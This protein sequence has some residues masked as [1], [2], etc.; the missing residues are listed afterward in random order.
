ML[1]LYPNEILLSPT[2]SVKE[3]TSG[4][5][6]NIKLMKSV[7]LSTENGAGL[8]AN[9]IGLDKSIFITRDKV[10]INPEIL[11]YNGE[12]SSVEGCLSFPEV[13]AKLKRAEQVVV[14]YLDELGENH[15][16]TIENFEAI[17]VQHEYDHLLG[18]TFLNHV[19][20]VQRNTILRK[21]KKWKKKHLVRKQN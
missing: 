19:G 21:I 16:E 20:P 13:R 17:I 11:K 3:I 1:K 5:L 8:A 9:Q 7:L 18:K 14:K 12:R 6:E 10:F 2:K 4:V 15:L